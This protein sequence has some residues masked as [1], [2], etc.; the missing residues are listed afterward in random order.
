MPIISIQVKKKQP[1]VHWESGQ[2]VIQEIAQ[3][4][5]EICWLYIFSMLSMCQTNTT[6]VLIQACCF[7][8][9]F[10]ST[11]SDS[12]HPFLSRS[13][14]AE[15][16]HVCTNSFSEGV[17]LRWSLECPSCPSELMRSEWMSCLSGI[18]S[19][20][21]SSETCKEALCHDSAA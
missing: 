10:N 14:Y 12:L 4:L 8:S 21:F 11:N 2:S 6:L 17:L 16:Q 20:M 18:R 19:Y 3:D 15:K 9:E 13:R 5:L 7:I 1:L